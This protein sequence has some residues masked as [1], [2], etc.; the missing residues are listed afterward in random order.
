MRWGFCRFRQNLANAKGQHPEF[1]FVAPLYIIP[2][3]KD[4]MVGKWVFTV[5]GAVRLPVLTYADNREL[6][7]KM[8]EAY[9]HLAMNDNEYNNFAIIN[10]IIKLSKPPAQCWY[11]VC[12]RKKQTKK[13]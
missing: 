11:F 1:P 13:C 5:H 6:R 3:P 10:K 8:Y 2:D 7:R 12:I 4:G 9:T